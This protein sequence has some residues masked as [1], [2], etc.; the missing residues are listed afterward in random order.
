RLEMAQ[1]KQ[2]ATVRLLEDA[3]SRHP[4]EADLWLLLA[5]AVNDGSAGPKK[6][7]EVMARAEKAAGDRPEFR[8][9]RARLADL[10][11]QPKEAREVLA[12]A[13]KKAAGL[14]EKEQAA[15]LR[16]LAAARQARGDRADAV[17]LYTRLTEKRPDDL[18]AWRALFELAAREGDRARLEKVTL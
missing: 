9:R 2:E 3:C 13:E 18:R 1:G 12:A 16:V 5:T 8:V 11:D 10:R 6:A 15:W 14:P 7:E 17:M 4:R